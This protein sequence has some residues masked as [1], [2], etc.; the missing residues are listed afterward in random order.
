MT[1]M[2]VLLFGDQT[3]DCHPLLRKLLHKKGNPVLSSF[4]ERANVALRDEITRLS[5]LLQEKMP[6]FTNIADLIERYQD[7]KSSSPAVESAVMCICQI[8]SFIR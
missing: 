6:Q 1:R 2:N 8:A 4:L 3:S 7:H 5:S